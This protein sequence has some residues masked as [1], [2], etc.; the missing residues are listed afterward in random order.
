MHKPPPYIGELLAALR[1]NDAEP[2]ALRRLTDAQWQEVLPLCDSTQLTLPL[3]RV[4]GDDLPEWVRARM[5]RNLLDNSERHERIKSAYLEM[6]DALRAGGPD[7]LVLKGFTHCPAFVD[8]PRHRRQGDLDLY[9]PPESIR[10]ARDALVS[11]GYELH[12]GFEHESADHLPPMVRK[13]NWTWVGNYFDPRMPL[14]V[15]VHFRFWND[16]SLRLHLEDIDQFWER[17]VERRIDNF[18]F[19]ALSAVDTVGYAAMHVFR[20]LPGRI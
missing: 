12:Q 7:H 8:H 19:P 6:A 17:R 3:L 4:C 1:L 20:H 18:S 2:E 14:W 16:K 13:T 15:E 9:A 5:D 10:Q 11:I